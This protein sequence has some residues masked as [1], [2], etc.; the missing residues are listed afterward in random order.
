MRSE[1]IESTNRELEMFYCFRLERPVE[2]LF[3]NCQFICGNILLRNN[4]AAYYFP[5]CRLQLQPAG[6]GVTFSP[7]SIQFRREHVGRPVRRKDQI[8]E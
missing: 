4:R 6:V 7:F 8:S 3:P 1:K 5:L 2:C